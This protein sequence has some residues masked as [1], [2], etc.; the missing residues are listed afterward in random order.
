MTMTDFERM[1]PLLATKAD[2]AA[3]AQRSDLERF[4]LKED[5]ERFATK[6]DLERFATKEDLERF[7]TKEELECGLGE[8]RSE[9]GRFA[10]KEDL[11]RGLSEVRAQALTLYEGILSEFRLLAELLTSRGERHEQRL[12]QHDREIASHGER[13]RRLEDARPR[14]ATR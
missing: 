10:T 5:L 3:C 9:L 8:L 14:G 1:L 12:D 4:A 2:V 11:E 6:K 13:I 7:A